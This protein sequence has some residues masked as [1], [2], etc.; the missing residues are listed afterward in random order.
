MASSNA[1]RSRASEAASAS[2]VASS[3]SARAMSSS[4]PM[5]PEKRLRTNR[6][7]SLRKPTVPETVAIS[8]SS[9]WSLK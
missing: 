4:L 9:A 3:V 7:C 5:P 1:A 6:T 8:A 2:V